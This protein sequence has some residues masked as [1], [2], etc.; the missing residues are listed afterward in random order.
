MACGGFGACIKCGGVSQGSAQTLLSDDCRGHGNDGALGR[1]RKIARG[2]RPYKLAHDC[3]PD[4]TVHPMP[5]LWLPADLVVR[6]KVIP[7]VADTV[8]REDMVA[9]CADEPMAV[10]LLAVSDSETQLPARPPK[11]R[12][13][14]P[15]RK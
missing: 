12:C 5:G 14:L 6:P 1:A 8:P 10:C 13:V 7:V 15:L 2:Q 4:G 9:G 3:W 11:R